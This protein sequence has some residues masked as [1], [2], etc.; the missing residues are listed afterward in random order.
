MHK[1]T[2][3]ILAQQVSAKAWTKLPKY[4]ICSQYE[5]VQTFFKIKNQFITKHGILNMT[6]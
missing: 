3:Q 1:K 5:P 4:D 6:F 2:R